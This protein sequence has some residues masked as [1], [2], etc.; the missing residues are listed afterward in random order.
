MKKK[1]SW[2]EWAKRIIIIVI[3][4]AFL[5]LAIYPAIMPVFAADISTDTTSGVSN[6]LKTDGGTL[7]YTLSDG[8][9]SI[10]SFSGELTD[11]LIPST[12]DNYPVT[13]IEDYAFANSS[14][15]SIIV[16]DSVKSIGKGAFYLCEKLEKVDFGANIQSLGDY[17]FY[18]CSS[19]KQFTIPDSLSTIPSYF[20]Y[21]C[22]S[23]ESVSI[24]DTITQ[25]SD[26]AF[27]ACKKL[28]TINFPKNLK[29]IGN[30][31]FYDCA[32]FTSMTFPESLTTIGDYAFY[33]CEGLKSFTLSTNLSSFGSGV[34]L[35]CT[36]LSKIQV[37][38]NN[39]Y[40]KE[41]DGVLY[42]K[43]GKALICYP[44]G[45]NITSFK[46]PSGVLHIDNEA[47]SQ[48]KDLTK[49]EFPNTLINICDYA[50][51]EC[52][53]LTKISLPKSLKTLGYDA[54][55]GCTGIKNIELPDSVTSIGEEVFADCTSL[56]S[57]QL[58]KSLEDIGNF[59]FYGCM[60][61][62]SIDL[63]SSLSTLGTGLFIA[64]TNLTKINV[65]KDSK[66]L[67]S[68]D[69]ILFTKDKKELVA[70][71]CNKN[72]EK[73][74][75]NKNIEKIRPYAFAFNRY[76]KE[77]ELPDSLTYIGERAFEGLD[78]TS[79]KIPKNVDSIDGGIFAFCIDLESVTVD[80]DNK[81]FIF[82]N[83]ILYDIDKAVIYDYLCSNKDEELVLDLSIAQLAD[84][85]FA[86]NKYLKSITLM[87]ASASIGSD[88]FAECSDDL[89]LHSFETSTAAIYARN[90]GLKFAKINDD[91][92]IQYTTKNQNNETKTTNTNKEV[93]SSQWH[94]VFWT[95]IGL[96]TLVVVCVVLLI[97]RRKKFK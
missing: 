24:P 95:T 35:G 56:E 39:Y 10:S 72:I 2:K 50:F 79:I 1:N 6:S 43:D 25:I 83:G 92:I 12:I 94:I 90:N 88:V 97:L 85:S 14:L 19:L 20:F 17:L 59:A 60:S 78:I 8:Q 4:L 62:K 68:D 67:F 53:G 49:I 45:K 34:L 77:I 47:F 52:T 27:Y 57:I 30:Y 65:S 9:I 71:P 44:K 33:H 66:N 84:S 22:F 64:C 40:Y 87:N 37:E 70:F 81:N 42:T 82:E 31:S 41:I 26:Y 75:V 15:S 80:K 36:S 76:I 55:Y 61:L 73:Y 89:V 3:I 63:P 21:A 18:Y 51:A 28:P 91:E 96:L 54:F 46:V 32:S 38:K 93:K 7:I 69:G 86:G 11:I 29:I 23:L 13:S 5:F 48:C 16:P 74:I 58:S